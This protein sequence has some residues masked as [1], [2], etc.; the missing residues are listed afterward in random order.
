MSTIKQRIR[1]DMLKVFVNT[2]GSTADRDTKC[3]DI[4]YNERPWKLS[5]G[6]CAARDKKMRADIVG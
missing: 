1:K 4:Q 5:N 2:T 3:D 6:I